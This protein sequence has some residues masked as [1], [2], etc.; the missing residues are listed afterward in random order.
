MR[1]GCPSRYRRYGTQDNKHEYRDNRCE[2]EVIR[3]PFRPASRLE[4]R[5]SASP[6]RKGSR[7]STKLVIA[8]QV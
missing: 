8:R 4:S 5:P 1:E 3:C 6:N 7:M 2:A